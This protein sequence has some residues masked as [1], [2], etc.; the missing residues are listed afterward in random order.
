[1]IE[2]PGPENDVSEERHEDADQRTDPDLLVLDEGDMA[3]LGEPP[4]IE[5]L[6]PEPVDSYVP[7]YVPDPPPE[8]LEHRRVHVYRTRSPRWFRVLILTAIGLILLAGASILH[9]QGYLEKW[10]SELRGPDENPQTA[11]ADESDPATDPA[12]ETPDTKPGPKPPT[13]KPDP[14]PDPE[15]DPPVRPPYLVPVPEVERLPDPKK[16]PRPEGPQPLVVRTSNNR[17]VTLLEGEIL[18][19]LRNGNFL[20]G[21]L[22]KLTAE[23]LRLAMA[24][25]YVDVEL[26]RLRSTRK[27]GDGPLRPVSAYPLASVRLVTG[28]VLKGRLMKSTER[29]VE[30]VFPSG[31]VVLRR[32]MVKLVWRR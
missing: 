28:E 13:V 17:E 22:H 16:A 20:K 4:G 19:E 1:V 8:S 21:R 7:P 24:G 15:P 27:N 12:P 23:S 29:E 26:S 3:A 25:G 11:V 32:D 31:K 9:R 30:L 14:K 18:V 5:D 10:F 6:E 2:P